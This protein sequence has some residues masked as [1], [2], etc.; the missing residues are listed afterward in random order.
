[1]VKTV[2][3]KETIYHENNSFNAAITRKQQ[4]KN[5]QKCSSHHIMGT[6]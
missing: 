1:M 3:V 2:R 6:I 4:K 5:P